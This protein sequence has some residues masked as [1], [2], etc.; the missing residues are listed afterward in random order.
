MQTR[1]GVSHQPLHVPATLIMST[2]TK[3]QTT[4]TATTVS[5]EPPLMRAI[6]L[7]VGLPAFI[8]GGTGLLIW[9]ETGQPIAAPGLLG[10]LAAVGFALLVLLPFLARRRGRRD[11]P[12]AFGSRSR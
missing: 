9:H 6:K 2:Q 3:A 10:L 11:E 8:F 7:L 12:L 5:A 1:S 4:P